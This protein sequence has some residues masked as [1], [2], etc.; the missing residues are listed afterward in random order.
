MADEQAAALEK[1][2]KLNKQSEDLNRNLNQ[3]NAALAAKL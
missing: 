2:R 1:A 3:K